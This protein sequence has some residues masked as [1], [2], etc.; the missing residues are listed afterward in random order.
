MTDSKAFK[1]KLIFT[2]NTGDEGNEDEGIPVL[3]KYL[4][5]FCKTLE[6]PLINYE[7]ILIL[8]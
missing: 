5:N 4:G 6:M 3:L 8:T 7:I 1:F 2:T